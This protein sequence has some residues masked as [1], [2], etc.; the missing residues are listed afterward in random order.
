LTN[1]PVV[2][3]CA[4]LQRGIDVRATEARERDDH[5]ATDLWSVVESGQDGIESRWVPNC[6]ECGNRSFATASVVVVG[7]GGD[8]R[9]NCSAGT[10][11]PEEPARS[12]NHQWLVV[13]QS[14]NRCGDEGG[15][16]A[17][18]SSGR[19]EF[20]RPP[21]NVVVGVPHGGAE[22]VDGERSTAL[23]CA[24]AGDSEIRS[25]ALERTLRN[26]D[27]PAEPGGDHRSAAPRLRVRL[28]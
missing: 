9:G 24:E 3:H 20:H 26:C 4:A 15:L 13:A 12:V 25:T 21:S 17:A 28:R 22:L 1:L 10:M 7:T 5:P 23:E 18:T 16:G 14:R 2:V 19:P 6:S 11:L 27:I 8:E